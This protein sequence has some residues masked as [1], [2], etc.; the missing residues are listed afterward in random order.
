MQTKTNLKIDWATHEAAKFACEKWHYSKCLPTGKTVKIG[1]WEDDKYIGV[2]IY[3][4]GANNNAAKSFN[5]NQTEVCELTRVALNKHKTAVSRILS[6]SLKF[7]NKQS[8]GIKIVFSYS[9]LSDQGHHGGIYQANGWLYIGTRSTSD[10]GAYY[11]INGKQMHGRSARAKYGSEK[12]FPNGWEHVKSKTKHL[13]VKVLDN[14]YILDKKVYSYP[15]RALSKSNVVPGF[16]SGEGGVIPTNAL[17][18]G[19]TTGE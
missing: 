3:S 14:N 7:L 2:I 13:Y 9:D 1:V 4:Y 16:Q 6:I 17:Q 12:N 10:K 5:L 19:V 18:L 11:I 8:P 15:K